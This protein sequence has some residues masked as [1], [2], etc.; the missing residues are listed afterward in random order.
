MSGGG[1]AV[2]AATAQRDPLAGFSHIFG[3]PRGGSPRSAA[4]CRAVAG[5]SCGPLFSP[6]PPVV[7][8]PT[9]STTESRGVGEGRKE[10]QAGRAGGERERESDTKRKSAVSEMVQ[11]SESEDGE[12]PRRQVITN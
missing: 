8:N 6:P 1:K 11:T 12:E 5:K 7:T 9:E 2:S 10:G 4:I 3:G